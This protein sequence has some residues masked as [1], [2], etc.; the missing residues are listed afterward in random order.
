MTTKRTK[1]F[2]AIAAGA[3]L[4]TASGTTLAR[5]RDSADLGPLTITTGELDIAQAATVGWMHLPASSDA[6]AA[7]EVSHP[8]TVEPGD[9]LVACVHATVQLTGD[10]LVALLDGTPGPGASW[11]AEEAPTAIPSTVFVG[12]PGEQCDDVLADRD[13]RTDRVGGLQASSSSQALPVVVVFDFPS[14]RPAGAGEGEPGVDV[15]LGSLVLR[16]EQTT[17]SSS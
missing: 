8:E 11:G 13:A 15:A 9:T 3:V 2:A 6:V 1:A 4:L 16:L 14:A 10:T 7:F 5:W 12:R 17:G